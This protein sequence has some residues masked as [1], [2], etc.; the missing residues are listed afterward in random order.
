MT[1]KSDTT[2]NAATYIFDKVDQLSALREAWEEGA[3]KQSNEELY[4]LLGECLDLYFDIKGDTKKVKALNDLLRNRTNN[5]S[6]G[7]SLETRIVRAIFD[8]NL[9]KRAYSYA[10]VIK[11]ASEEKVPTQSMSEFIK[12]RDGIEELR[13]K[14]TDGKT[15]AETRRDNIAFAKG[16]LSKADPLVAPFKVTG[17][18]LEIDE[19]AEHDLFVAVMRREPD[20]SRSLVFETSAQSVINVAL[21]R[22]GK[23]QGA[24]QKLADESAERKQ[25]AIN[26]EQAIDEAVAN[27]KAA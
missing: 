6:E 19:G 25:T 2:I 13:R 15:P 27:A 5:F 1:K 24:K 26:S 18:T 3:Y 11:I 14:K 9:K 10:K 16:S 20:G 21:E 8:P 22:A 7:A 17:S 4:G 23:E 12:S